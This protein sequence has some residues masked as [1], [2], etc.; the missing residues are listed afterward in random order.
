MH[1]TLCLQSV[2]RSFAVRQGILQEPL[3]LK[4]V[5]AITITLEKGDMLGLVGESGCGKSTLGRMVAG[6]LA[7]SSG[8]IVIDGKSLYSAKG[9]VVHDGSIQM[10]F[11]D[12]YSSLNPRLPI[13][14]SI[15]E[16][17]TVQGINK[18]EREQRVENMLDMVGFVKEQAKRYP[19]EFSG[20]QRQRI[21]V[22]RALITEPKI[23][24]C[25]EPVSA[26]DASV[27]AQV[28]NLLCQVQ[29]RFSPTCLFISHD[30]SVVGFLCPRITVMYLGRMVE[31]APRQTLFQQAAHPYTQALLASIPSLDPTQKITTPPL[32]GELPSPLSPP[33]GC[34]FHPRC[35]KA[36]PQ[37]QQSSPTW[38]TLGPKHRVCCHLYS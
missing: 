7:P 10:I 15:A 32:C 23:L 9:K 19:H 30:L 25:D 26:L 1:P 37:C 31:D 27:Q 33:A 24:I 35:P 13:G 14:V 20:G 17:L 12:P 2:S 28:L 18:A 3:S 29:E 36:M 38:T 4:A 8:D 34:A 11:Q 22:A 21:A 6:L 16:P 5:D